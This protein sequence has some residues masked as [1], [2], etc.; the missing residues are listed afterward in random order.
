MYD[1]MYDDRYAYPGTFTLRAC[2]GCGHRHLDADFRPEQLGILY[3]EYYPRSS[4][5]VD[6]YAPYVEVGGARAWFQGER[7]SAFRWVPRDVRILD[8]GC[9]FCSTLGYHAA[10]GCDV[11]GVEADSN[12]RRVAEKFGF[13]VKIGLFSAADYPADFFDYVTM[14]Q[15]IEHVTQ[16]HEVLSGIRQVLKPGGTA[17]FSTP[18][19]RSIPAMLFGRRWLNWHTPYHL[20]HYSR[21]S[22]RQACEQAGLELVSTRSLTNAEWLRYQWAHSARFP[23]LGQPSPFWSHGVEPSRSFSAILARLLEQ[24]HRFKLNHLLTRLFDA[25]GRGDNRLYFVRKPAHG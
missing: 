2:D 23:R 24:M 21:E 18:F 5:S 7:C 9:G 1:G 25:L 4:I 6:D 15:V 13:K 14:D 16:P 10:R 20:Q 11:Y 12:A 17:I 22:F 19:S 3:S 8:I